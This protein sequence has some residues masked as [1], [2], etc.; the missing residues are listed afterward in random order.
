MLASISFTDY[1]ICQMDQGLLI[2]TVF[3]ELPK[4]FDTTRH[5]E[6]I[7]PRLETIIGNSRMELP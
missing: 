4:V 2:G 1:T 3:T 7:V 6:I 5:Y